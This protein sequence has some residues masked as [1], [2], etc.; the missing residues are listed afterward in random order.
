M[1]QRPIKSVAKCLDLLYLFSTDRPRWTAGGLAAAMGLP[2]STIYRYLVTLRQQGTLE[3]NPHDRSYRLSPRLLQ[4]AEA[5]TAELDLIRRARPVMEGLARQTRETVQLML[6]TGDFGTCVDR[7]ESPEAL[8]VRPER[9][10]SVPLHAGASMKAILAFLPAEEQARLL[11]RPL[12]RLTGSTTT[13]PRTLRAELA[14][15]RKSGYAISFQEVYPGVR[16]VSAPILNQAGVAIGSLGVAGPGARLTDALART[17]A[18][19]LIQAAAWLSSPARESAA[20]AASRGHGTERGGERAQA[21]G[22][23]AGPPGGEQGTER[24]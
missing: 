15:I 19:A 24:E 8:L 5:L 12:Q 17:M 11:R 22:S 7:A 21:D 18:P 16:A 10:R 6:R 9:G 20:V 13:N 23:A 4:L 3:E 14:A 2:L 1:S